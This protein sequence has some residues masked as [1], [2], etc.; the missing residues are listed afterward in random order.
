MKAHALT[1][2]ATS[3][4]FAAAIHAAFADGL[5]PVPDVKFVGAINGHLCIT[6]DK[7][8]NPTNLFFQ[9]KSLDFP[10]TDWRT[11]EF[12]HRSTRIAINSNTQH[13]FYRDVDKPGETL[14]RVAET[15]SVGEHAGWQTAGPVTNCLYYATTEKIPGANGYANTINDGIINTAREATYADSGQAMQTSTNVWIGV[16]CGSL[17]D[18]SMVRY[19]PRQ[20]SLGLMRMAKTKIQ[21]ADDAAFLTNLVNIANIDYSSLSLG[22]V[23]E[24]A[25]EPPAK[26]RYFRI[27]RTLPKLN[28]GE[29]IAIDEIEVVRKGLPKA[30][31]ISAANS[32]DWT[33]DWPAVTWSV[34]A[35]DCCNT[36]VLQRALSAAGPFSDVSAWTDATAGERFVDSNV[37]VGVTY[38]Y[39]VMAQCV[40]G[41]HRSVCYSD[42]V[43][44]TRA[45]RLERSWD[46]LT[47]L[48][49]GMS[50]MYPLL[51]AGNNGG[52]GSAR[53]SFD[54]NT[55]TFTE[56]TCYTNA[57]GEAQ[58]PA[59]RVLDPVV[60]VDLGA[61]YH[62]TGAL[63]YPR[64][65][66]TANLSRA[67]DLKICGADEEA[68]TSCSLLSGR[69]GCFTNIYWHYTSTTNTADKFRFVFL[70][71]GPVKKATYGNV[72]EVGFY[73]FSD[74]DIID[75]GL[76]I[77]PT[78]VS[79]ETNATGV[80]VA[81]DC[82]WN[83]ASYSVERSRAGVEEWTAVASVETNVLSLV[84]ESVPRKG[85][86][87]WRVT[88][89]AEG[90]DTISSL[91]CRPQYC[92]PGR[93]MIIMFR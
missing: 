49:A 22:R 20:D 13:S 60:G 75:S 54:G 86:W 18:A 79:C 31:S 88:A 24:I 93:G 59:N 33:N 87:Q 2:L 74:Q 61:E 44:Y 17:V 57:P 80:A 52:I 48:N 85:E 39:R 35:E 37:V 29:Y 30:F 47:A 38:Y 71:A 89:V 78:T 40:A 84:D 12:T 62:I 92:D 64:A 27:M 82:G 72:A 50:V 76:L 73:G 25:I 51:W 56:T 70:W 91:P 8:A 6:L 3:A 7:S 67:N 5:P 10:E 69:L 55:A 14:V 21:C 32:G 81:W 45:R 68:F 19:V 36:G 11:V 63:V 90:G 43:S 77:P 16:D 28:S 9:V 26:A 15:N 53:N 46:D 58:A 42:V 66:S 23:F 1:R 83:A 34:P 65:D 41:G 4:A